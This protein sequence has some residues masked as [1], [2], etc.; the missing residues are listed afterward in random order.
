MDVER[1]VLRTQLDHEI[2]E[3]LE[4]KSVDFIEGFRVAAQ[5]LQEYFES[6]EK[7]DA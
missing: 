6:V 5:L 2:D 3:A 7:L 4:G 1:Q